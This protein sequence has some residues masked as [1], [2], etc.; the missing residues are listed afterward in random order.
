MACH[1]LSCSTAL[2]YSDVEQ[3]SEMENFQIQMFHSTLRAAALYF[4][5]GMENSVLC[6]RRL[7]DDSGRTVEPQASITC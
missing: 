7:Q 4:Q 1:F 3:Q 2:S 6:L 5:S